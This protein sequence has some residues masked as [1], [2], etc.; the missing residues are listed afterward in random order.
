MEARIASW[1]AQPIPLSAPRVVPSA[2][3]HS[4]STIVRMGSLSKSCWV[5]AF[6]RRSGLGHD[7]VPYVVFLVGDPVFLG[8]LLKVSDDLAFLLRGAWY[9]GDFVEVLPDD[10]GVQFGNF[11]CS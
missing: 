5:P 8:E 2:C 7:D 4:P 6:F 11:H 9:L 3:S 1:A 10:L